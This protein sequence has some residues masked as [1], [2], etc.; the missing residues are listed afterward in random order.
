MVR[1]HGRK[2]CFVVLSSIPSTR[3]HHWWIDVGAW[4]KDG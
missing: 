4:E 2:A 1:A 3:V